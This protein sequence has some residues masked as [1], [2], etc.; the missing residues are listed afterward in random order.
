M[1]ERFLGYQQQ[2]FGCSHL[3]LNNLHAFIKVFEEMNRKHATIHDS[4]ASIQL[5]KA[6]NASFKSNKGNGQS[7][8][9]F[10]ARLIS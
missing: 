9:K 2:V 4:V 5:V 8:Q 6:Q 7:G 10:Q 3:Q 1:F